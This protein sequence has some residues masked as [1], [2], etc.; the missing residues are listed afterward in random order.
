MKYIAIV[1]FT[2]ALPTIAAQGDLKGGSQYEKQLR[3]SGIPILGFNY[4]RA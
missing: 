2:F 4:G 1:L 3:K